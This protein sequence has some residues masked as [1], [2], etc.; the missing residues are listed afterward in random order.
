[1]AQYQYQAITGVGTVPTFST[2]TASDTIVPDDRGFLVLKN[3]NAATRTVTIAAPPSVD[4]APSTM[5]DWTWTLA[6]TTGELWIPM[7]AIYA[8]STGIITVTITPAITN[9][10]SA[11]VRR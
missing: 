9:V 5:P 8:D 4:I 10:T 1:M 11:A 6:A 3:T 2:P 7:L